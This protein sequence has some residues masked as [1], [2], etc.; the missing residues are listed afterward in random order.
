MILPYTKLNDGLDDDDLLDEQGFPVEMPR[1]ER[2]A[3][4]D[5]EY[6]FCLFKARE[7]NCSI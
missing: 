3:I 1:E 7:E 4:E 2:Q 6:T 5:A